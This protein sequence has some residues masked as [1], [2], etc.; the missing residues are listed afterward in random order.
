MSWEKEKNM[1]MK[2]DIINTFFFILNTFLRYTL[3]LILSSVY[4]LLLAATPLLLLLFIDLFLLFTFGS[5]QN[6]VYVIFMA[7]TY[8]S[9]DILI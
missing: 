9:K 3:K 1:Y 7:E 4:F 6:D 5:K 2:Q 8:T